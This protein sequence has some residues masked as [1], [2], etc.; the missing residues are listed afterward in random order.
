MATPSRNRLDL[1]IEW[2]CSRSPRIEY[3]FRQNNEGYPANFFLLSQSS[4]H[5]FPHTLSPHPLAVPG[6][7]TRSFVPCSRGESI[8]V[9]LVCVLCILYFD[10]CVDA[11]TYLVPVLTLYGKRVEKGEFACTSWDISTLYFFYRAR[12]VLQNSRHDPWDTMLTHEIKGLAGWRPHAT[13][14]FQLADIW[15][16]GKGSSFAFILPPTCLSN[17][18]PSLINPKLKG[19]MKLL[20]SSVVL[21]M[22]ATHVVADYVRTLSFQ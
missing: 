3:T 18:P 13:F 10:A 2:I 16:G 7:P 5:N 9:I 4:L 1:S 21:F 6:S 20:S 17:S 19:I 14:Q 22:A 15:E 12:S 8:L 11:S